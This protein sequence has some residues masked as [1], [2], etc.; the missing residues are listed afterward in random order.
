VGLPFFEFVVD[1]AKVVAKVIVTEVA[2]VEV[3]VVSFKHSNPFVLLSTPHSPICKPRKQTVK[4][5]M[6]FSVISNSVNR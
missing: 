3:V 6:V 1:F 4:Y 5:Q 2:V